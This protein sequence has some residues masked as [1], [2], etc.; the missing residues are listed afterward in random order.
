MSVEE[1]ESNDRDPEFFGIEMMH[2][3]HDYIIPE[4]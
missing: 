3:E 2:I 4:S 1:D